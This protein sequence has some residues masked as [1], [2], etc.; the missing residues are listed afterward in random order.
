[1]LKYA[2]HEAEYRK[3]HC[4]P[5]GRYDLPQPKAATEWLH[6]SVC[7]SSWTFR[8]KPISILPGARPPHDDQ[9]V[10]G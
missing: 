3:V 2:Y 7:S 8:F 6:G 4:T 10:G 1:M 5:Y 9:K